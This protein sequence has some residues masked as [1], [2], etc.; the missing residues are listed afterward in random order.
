[1]AFQTSL[2]GL[3]AA[4]GNLSVTG[5]NIANA[6]TTGFKKSRA[7]FADVYAASVYGSSSTTIGGGVRLAS[8]AQQ[9]TQGNIEFTDNPLDLAISGEGFFRLDDNGATVFSR[10]GMF[11]VDANGNI[12][13]STGQGLTGYQA[14]ASGTIT[15]ALGTL[16]V[17]TSNID[18]LASTSVDV[19]LNLNSQEPLP[20]N[21]DNTSTIT[22]GGDLDNF[23]GAGGTTGGLGTTDITIVDNSGNS[24]PAYV[25]YTYVGVTGTDWTVELFAD[26]GAGYASLGTVNLDTATTPTGQITWTPTNGG[27][28]QD[29][30]TLTIDGSALTTISTLGPDSSDTTESQDGI[31]LLAFD[32]SD[33]STF[34]NTTSLTVYDSLGGSHQASLY[35]VKLPQGNAWEVY[36]YIDG[37]SQSGGIGRD[38]SDVI[39]FDTSGSIDEINN[40]PIPPADF[41]TNTFTPAGAGASTP[42][43]MTLTFDLTSVSQFGAP[44]SVNALTQDGYTTGQLSGLDIAET[45]VVFARYTNGQSRSLGQVA[46]VNFANPQGLAPQGDTL[47]AETFDSGQPLVGTP[48][49]SSLGLIQS[50][51]LESSNVDISKQL[52]NMIVAQ[53]DFQ[54]N[55]KMISTEDA[56]TQSIINIR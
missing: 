47:W 44:F 49:S 45:G 24:I 4:Q 19:N 55:A 14:D 40:T 9:F 25:E 33:P 15:G 1:M 34:N 31:P 6:S 50:G 2:S 26:E 5:N 18:P 7:E 51:A 3:A 37:V 23:I 38:S 41:Q 21:A 30:I 28:F 27:G 46:L 36:T 17:D 43:D 10:A 8:V 48:G 39:E 12:V 35:F 20:N 16:Q 52:V 53:R 54:A 29:D 56:V 32:P 42:A 13:N 11:S 22:L